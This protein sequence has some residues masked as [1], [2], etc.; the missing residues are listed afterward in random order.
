MGACY[1]YKNRHTVSGKLLMEHRYIMTQYVGRPLLRGELVHHINGDKSDNRLSNL[2]LMSPREHCIHHN[3]KHPI[4]KK[5]QVCGE[6]Y[7]PRA[8]KREQSKTCLKKC[9]YILTSRTN[10]RPECAH[11][12]YNDGAFPSMKKHRKE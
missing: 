11:S 12:M 8:T 6:E 3:Q 9:R 7:V 4:V 1:V 2:M 5:C 10:R